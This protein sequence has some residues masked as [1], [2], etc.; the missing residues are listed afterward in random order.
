MT[1]SK[2]PP[3]QGRIVKFDPT[4]TTGTIAQII[5]VICSALGIFLGLRDDQKQTKADLEQVKA[6][7]IVERVQTAQALAEVKARLDKQGDQLQDIKESLAIL[8][9]R[10][11]ETTGSKR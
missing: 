6:V 7:A 4:F 8:R 3:D 2:Q 11:A 10:A 9:G 5:V 1:A